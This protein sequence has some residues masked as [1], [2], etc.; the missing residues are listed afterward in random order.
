MRS[1]ASTL[2]LALLC[3]SAPLHLHAQ[4]PTQP[5]ASPRTSNPHISDKDFQEAYDTIIVGLS[6]N[7]ACKTV[8]DPKHYE[9]YKTLLRVSL[10]HMGAQEDELAKAEESGVKMSNSL[11]EERGECWRSLLELPASTTKEAGRTNCDDKLMGL[12]DYVDTLLG[13]P[14]ETDN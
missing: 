14:S 7:E 11:C 2:A 10:E 6:L 4:S 8:L 5:A 9:G 12:L 3:M 13:E 1:I